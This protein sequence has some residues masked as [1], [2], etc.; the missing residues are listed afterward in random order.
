MKINKEMYSLLA[1]YMLAPELIGSS[2]SSIR[3]SSSSSS[4]QRLHGNT[5]LLSSSVDSI[6]TSLRCQPAP[7]PDPSW[8][9]LEWKTKK[10]E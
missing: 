4:S 7:I 1:E 5:H 3:P 10:I 9:I 8:P 6:T 2:L